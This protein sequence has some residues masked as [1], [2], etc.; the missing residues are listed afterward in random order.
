MSA[1]WSVL[2]LYKDPTAQEKAMKFCDELVRRFWP[3]SSF[4]LAWCCWAD[5]HHPA[6]AKE[7][8]GQVR[9]ANLVVLAA[10]ENGHVPGWVRHWLELALADRGELEGALVALPGLQSAIDEAAATAQVYLRKLAHQNGLDFLT[11]VPQSLQSRVPESLESY[12]VRATQV[13]SVLD[14]IL[15]QFPPSNRML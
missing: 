7:A 6:K 2:N 11:T 8:E 14:R 10:G 15:S 13:T 5:L 12:N 1:N 4:D 3:D 9:T